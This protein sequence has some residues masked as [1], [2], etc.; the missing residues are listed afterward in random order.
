MDPHRL[1][2]HLLRRLGREQLRHSRLEVGA[3]AR[4][5]ALRRLE[6]EEPSRL[7]LGRH[8][9]E[10]QLDRLV[11]RDRLAE[12]LPLLR[13]ADRLLEGA[14]RDPD[15]ARCDVDAA[16]LD[17]THEVAEAFADSR[18]AADHGVAGHAEAVEGE[19][20]GLDA[21][22]AELAERRP[23]RQPRELRR[24][25][26]LLEDERGDPAVAWLRLGVGLGEQRHHPRPQ[27][28]GRPHLLAADRPVVA[29]AHGPGPN[30][31]HV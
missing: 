11:L 31:L 20:D 26:L 29:V 22:V 10:L 27:A 14:C 19:L 7:D 25:R 8:L 5:L 9:R 15:C 17:P 28:V 1:E 30:R 21:L 13:V 23:D 6:H 4:V 16:E 18:L 3:L 2:R 12:R 24:A